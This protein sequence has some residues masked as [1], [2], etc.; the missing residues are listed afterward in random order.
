M[1]THLSHSLRFTDDEYEHLLNGIGYGNLNAPIWF[2]ATQEYLKDGG[3]QH[4]ANYLH[5]RARSVAR[6]HDLDQAYYPPDEYEAIPPEHIW[7][8]MLAQAVNRVDAWDDR[9]R[10]RKYARRKLARV[11]GETLLAHLLPLLQA[12]HF[13]WLYLDRYPSYAHYQMSLLPTRLSL[14]RRLIE[15]RK[16]YVV[17]ASG[18]HYAAWYRAMA[19]DCTWHTLGFGQRVQVCRIGDTHLCV[20]PDLAHGVNLQDVY[21]T[22]RYLWNVGRSAF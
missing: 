6:V 4:I 2:V 14:L 5:K 7:M 19:H 9:A 13:G 22:L 16:P 10:A 20:L 3:I 8:A 12:A 18:T 15:Q 17:F 21:H 1:M 11:H